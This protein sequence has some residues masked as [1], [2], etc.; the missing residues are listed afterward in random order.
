MSARHRLSVLDYFHTRKLGDF[1]APYA[2]GNVT[3]A[4]L[5]R[6]STAEVTPA[7]ARLWA[8]LVKR[9]GLPIPMGEAMRVAKYPKN[10]KSYAELNTLTNLWP[11]LWQ[12]DEGRIGLG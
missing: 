8:L 7:R 11:A 2:T 1:F 3:D 4:Q 12:D 5:C 10:V 9:A 6:R